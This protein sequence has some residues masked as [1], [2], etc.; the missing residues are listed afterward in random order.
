MYNPQD[1]ASKIKSSAKDKGKTVASVL[2]ECGLGKNTVGKIESGTDVGIST[3]VEIADCIGVSIDLLLGRTQYLYT[4][5]N[6]KNNAPDNVRS[7][8]VS[9]IISLPDSRLDRLLGFL[10]GLEEE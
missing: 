8:I 2:K 10:E 4:P 7:V 6:I 9:K 5:E 3:V 1:F